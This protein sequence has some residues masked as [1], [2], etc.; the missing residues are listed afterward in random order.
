MVGMHVEEVKVRHSVADAEECLNELHVAYKACGMK[1]MRHESK[2]RSS[3]NQQIHSVWG[4]M[5]TVSHFPYIY[6]KYT[7][8]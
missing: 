4:V 1:C 5:K 2:E 6:A 3:N 7:Y 8:I